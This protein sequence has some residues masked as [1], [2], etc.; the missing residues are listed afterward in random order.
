[1]STGL[2]SLDRHG[3]LQ[4]VTCADRQT[5]GDPVALQPATDHLLG[6]V[7]GPHQRGDLLQAQVLGL[8]DRRKGYKTD[9][10]K[11][12]GGRLEIIL[13]FRKGMCK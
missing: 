3:A 4:E 6:E 13:S 10:I 9:R 5:P 2:Y 8:G 7:R 11:L 1:M 12:N